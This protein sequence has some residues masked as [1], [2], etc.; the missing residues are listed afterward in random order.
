MFLAFP[1]IYLA[2]S[3]FLVGTQIGNVWHPTGH[4]GIRCQGTHQNIAEISTFSS[5]TCSGWHYCTWYFPAP[6]PAPTSLTKLLTLHILQ[7][8]QF[9]FPSHT[10]ASYAGTPLP[11]AQP[12]V[13]SAPPS[14]AKHRLVTIDEFC[15][16][17]N[18]SQAD[19]EHLDKLDYQPGDAIDKLEWVD[20]HDEA[21]FA[22]LGW[23]HM[24]GTH[25]RFL[26]DVRLGVWS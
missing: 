15:T 14:P 8:S 16:Y 7:Q 19:R 5:S 10:P 22:K 4:Y 2:H 26:R 3:D 6:A 12:L 25:R 17:Y 23:E 24:L 11:P 20:W 21:G 9:Q 13:L 18:V 1:N